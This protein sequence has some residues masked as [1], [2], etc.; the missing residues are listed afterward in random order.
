MSREILLVAGVCMASIGCSLGGSQKPSALPPSV[1]VSHPIQR[2]VTDYAV[3]TGRTAAV[4][5]VAIIPRATGYIVQI[6][7]KE[8]ADVKAGDLLFEIDPRPYQALV[9]Q[10][11]AQVA[12]NQA[13][14]RSTPTRR[15]S[16][17]TWP[18][19]KQ[20]AVKR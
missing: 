6:P 1:T 12:L 17:A 19:I 8:G 5:S 16:R 10:A 18:R 7:F 3:Y 13:R 20:S 14:A 2:E 15:L 11:R 4:K 9:N